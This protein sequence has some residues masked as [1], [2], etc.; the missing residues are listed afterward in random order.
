MRRGGGGGGFGGLGGGG[1]GGFGGTA[2][3]AVEKRNGQILPIGSAPRGPH[4]A[5]D[6]DEVLSRLAKERTMSEQTQYLTRKEQ[7]SAP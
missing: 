2:R 5:S 3:G 1:F 7:W 6:C 4:A